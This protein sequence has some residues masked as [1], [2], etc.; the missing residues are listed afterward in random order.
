MYN[1]LKW[2]NNNKLY[3]YIYKLPFLPHPLGGMASGNGIADDDISMALFNSVLIIS[4]VFYNIIIFIVINYFLL[5]IK[6]WFNV[7]TLL[8]N[9]IYIW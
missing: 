8:L 3:I 2:I 7:I 1:S 9:Y 4:L 6:W 5:D